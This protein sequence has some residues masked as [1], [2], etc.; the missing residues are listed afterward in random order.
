MKFQADSGPAKQK[1]EGTT[2]KTKPERQDHRRISP[3]GIEYVGCEVHP[4]VG[5]ADQQSALDVEVG[6][7]C[8]SPLRYE[9]PHDTIP[10]GE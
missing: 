1:A 2:S 6:V 9:T 10:S 5:E 7:V 3:A 4:L 8:L